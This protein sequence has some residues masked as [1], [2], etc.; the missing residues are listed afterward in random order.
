MR[1]SRYEARQGDERKGLVR[2]K[3]SGPPQ[4]FLKEENLE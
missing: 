4:E 2:E 1:A 3:G